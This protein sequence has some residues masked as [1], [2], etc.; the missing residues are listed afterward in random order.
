MVP[1]PCTQT[2]TLRTPPGFLGTRASGLGVCRKGQFLLSFFPFIPGNGPGQL[3]VGGSRSRDVN[4]G[5]Y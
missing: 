1:W 4:G 3:R 5:S 2:T